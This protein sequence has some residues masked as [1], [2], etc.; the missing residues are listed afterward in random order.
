[1]LHAL[2]VSV[3]GNDP[4]M[5]GLSTLQE[6]VEPADVAELLVHELQRSALG[7]ARPPPSNPVQNAISVEGT[8]AIAV[9]K[10]F[11]KT[12][13]GGAGWLASCEKRLCHWL[14]IAICVGPT[15]PV[16]WYTVSVT[17]SRH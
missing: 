1:M 13:L 11:C 7:T 3:D 5:G 2:V 17:G 10:E 9:T 16:T 8:T 14:A 6:P 12:V 4:V 15:T